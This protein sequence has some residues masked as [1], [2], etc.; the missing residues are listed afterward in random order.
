MEAV[1]LDL[2]YRNIVKQALFG[3]KCDRLSPGEDQE[4]LDIENNG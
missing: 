3:A 2:T 1:R 4:E